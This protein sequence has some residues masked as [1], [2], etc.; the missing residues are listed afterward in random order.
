MNFASLTK[1][2]LAGLLALE[3]FTPV[4]EQ[5]DQIRREA[6]GN[7]VHIR[8]ILEFSNHCKR[9]CLYCGLNRRNQNV[10]RYRMKPEEI[11]LTARS[12]YEAGY[13]TLVLQS[14]EDPYFK[15][16]LL[17]E[18]VKEIA[19]WGMA[20]T[21]SCGEIRPAYGPLK[22]AGASRYLLKHET[23]DALLYNRLHPEGSLADRIICLKELKAL[24]FETGS[25]FMVGLPGQTL[26][27][28]AEDLLLLK[29]LNCDMAGIGPFIPHPA[30]P[31]KEAAPGNPELTKRCVALARILLP[32]CHLPATT[33]LGVM[34]GREKE[35][36]F[37]CGAN[38]VMRK[39]T[40]EPYKSLYEIYPA[41]LG[42]TDIPKDRALL[43]EQI[44]A[45]GRIPI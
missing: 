33:A 10:S 20:V 15:T 35:T 11:L 43:E 32:H 21:V 37:S 41:H 30:T 36:V 40:P 8:A 27:T 2:D 12:A 9:G 19:S 3:D 14:G 42:P 22:K 6:K 28:L 18:L 1:E 23:A 45:L 5:A 29:K 31:L 26:E 39:V 25:G 4:Y 44:L 7:Q 24:G 17:A 16:D 13:Q 34:D 38:V